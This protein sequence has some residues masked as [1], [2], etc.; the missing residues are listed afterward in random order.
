MNERL[1]QL[2]ALGDSHC[3]EKVLAKGRGRAVDDVRERPAGM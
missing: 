2:L 1:G 3:R